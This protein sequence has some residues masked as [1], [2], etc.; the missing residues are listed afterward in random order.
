M[1]TVE[2]GND[3]S[4]EFLKV[5]DLL[6]CY[7]TTTVCQARAPTWH[8]ETATLLFITC[9]TSLPIFLTRR[10]SNPESLPSIRPFQKVET[11]KRRIS[12]ILCWSNCTIFLTGEHG[13]QQH[14]TGELFPYTTGML[15]VFLTN[16]FLGSVVYY[17]LV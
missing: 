8:S 12:K 17:S 9:T 2:R 14:E 10:A 16:K 5:V 4:F 7:V 6:P 1:L 3:L 11:V 15:F 13:R